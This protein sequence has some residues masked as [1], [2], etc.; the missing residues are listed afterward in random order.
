MDIEPQTDAQAVETYLKLFLAFR[1]LPETK[2][3]RT[4]LEVS[5][6]PHYENVASNILAFYFD[7]TEEHGLKDLLLSAFLQMAEIKELPRMDGVEVLR[8]TGTDAANRID[9][10]IDSEAFTIGIENKIFHWLANDLEQYAQVINRRGDGK[11]IVIRAVLGLNSIPATQPL[12]GGFT[13]YTY[14]QLWKQVRAIL[15]QYIANANPKWVTYLIDF[16]ETT[17]NLAGKNMDLKRTDQFFI[18]HN[19]LIENLL[20]ERNAFL[21]RLN[22]RVTNLCAMI[23]EAGAATALSQRPWIYKGSCVVLDF[24]LAES[25]TIAFDLYLKPVGWELQ[26]FGRN[27]NSAGFLHKLIRQPAIQDR[28][29]NLRFVNERYIVKNWLLQTD[30]GEIRFETPYVPG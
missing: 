8:E 6:Y 21:N 3:N 15:G 16:M 10:I 25:Y 23:D 28:A 1:T 29:E 22:Q 12:K 7:P 9:L 30:L 13:S 2:R 14:G 20:A 11:N 5:G 24:R 26:L 4:L 19:D 18:D 17:T 27:R